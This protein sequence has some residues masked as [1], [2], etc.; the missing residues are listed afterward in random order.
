MI[1]VG[2]TGGIGSGKSTVS[3]ML[4]ARGA[5]VIDADLITREVQLPGSVVVEEIARRFGQNVLDENGALLRA[6]LAEI[7]F[8]DAK[9]LTDLNKI[10]HPA[11]R[12][13]IA[14]RVDLLASTD[15]I[16]VL[17]IPLLTENRRGAIQAKIVVDVPVEQ[18]VERL[19]SSRGFTESDARARIAN[20][21]S[22]EERLRDADFVIDNSGDIEDLD[23]Q[24]DKLWEW[25]GSLPQL[26][27]DFKF[28]RAPA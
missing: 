23:P 12:A 25:I 11:V 2:L 14:R 21:S 10:V 5:E 6:K 19:V 27:N 7:V 18:Q 8:A 9:S 3:A 26:P 13:E 16:V 28:V 15:R 17:D 24:I 20:Q 4:A 1:L 22:R